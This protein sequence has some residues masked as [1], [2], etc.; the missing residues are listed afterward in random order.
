MRHVQ[1]IYK[2]A[3]LVFLLIKVLGGNWSAILSLVLG[4]MELYM[5]LRGQ[6]PEVATVA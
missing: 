6:G 1:T 4:M 3:E 5:E 2:M